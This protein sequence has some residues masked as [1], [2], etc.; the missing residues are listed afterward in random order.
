L[1]EN[2]DPEY[3]KFVNQ[4]TGNTKTGAAIDISPLYRQEDGRLGLPHE[5]NYIG[6]VALAM[7]KEVN[8]AHGRI[9]DMVEGSPE[10]DRLQDET[11][12]AQQPG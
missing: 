10:R 11:A 3:V 5:L 7:Q 6:N 1:P 9:A 4:L 8:S 2:P 12:L